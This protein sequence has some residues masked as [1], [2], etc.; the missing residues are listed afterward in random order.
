MNSFAI[1]TLGC[2]VNSYESEAIRNDL[3]SFGYIEHDFSNIADIYIINTCSV[4][5]NADSKSRNMISKARRNNPNA[6]VIVMG[7]YSQ[8]SSKEIL[9]QKL[10]DIIIGN[11][12][13]NN[14]IN[15]INEYQ[16]EKKTI[17]KISNLLIEKEFEKNDFVI[18]QNKTRAYIK[19][20]DGCN[21]MC[22]YCIIPFTRG[23]Q[24]S[25]NFETIINEVQLL[26][27]KGY[28][29]IVLTGVNIA[30]YENN[31]HNFYDFLLAI[32]NID[33]NFRIR[34]SSIEPFQITDEMINLISSNKNRFANHWHICLQSGS[35]NILEKMNRKYTT[36]DIRI[37]FNKIREKSPDVS[38][39]TDVIS[40][41]PTETENDHLD[42][43][44]FIKEMKFSS[45]HVF[46]FSSRK[47]T[48]ASTYIEIDSKTKKNRT[49]ELIKLSDELEKEYLK[50]FINKEVNV[51]FE[52][53]NNDIY[54][55]KTSEYLKCSYRSDEKITPN[56]IHNFLVD[57]VFLKTLILKKNNK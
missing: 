36:D 21:F 39:S 34:I 13:K 9:E 31:N 23:K 48:R 45:L 17:V 26:V 47:N 50:T 55:G 49:D 4:T 41:F 22:S 38:I 14:L 25:Q 24:R 3:L 1:K 44:N 19:I 51:I 54:E 52:S 8:V 29:E 42:T 37:L 27:E 11:K 33:G 20:Q 6:L 32:N 18:N 43:I 7:C 16:L 46:P 35:N 30:G 56:N 5:N 53:N 40:S 12:H 28:Q 57:K 10:A 2:K 15:L